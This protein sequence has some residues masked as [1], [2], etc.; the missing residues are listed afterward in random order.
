MARRPV[1]DPTKNVLDLVRVEKK[2]ARDLRAADKELKAVLRTADIRR[3]DDL[4]A[5]RDRYEERISKLL[6]DQMAISSNLLS[7][8][9]AKVTADID[10]RIGPLE[11]F[12][13]EMGGRTTGRG[14]IFAC[15]F[16]AMGFAAA[17][18]TVVS[19]FILRGH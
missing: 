5:M 12:R 18:V 11:R 8:Q 14:D 6:S 9:V 3:V 10:A 13:Y 1:I 15:I 17:V 16:G 7:A 2:H 4:A 19:F